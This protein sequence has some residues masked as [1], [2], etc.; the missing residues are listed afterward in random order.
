[1]YITIALTSP[2][3]PREQ[4]IPT[5]A[6]APVES[7]EDV[8]ASLVMGTGKEVEDDSGVE[9]DEEEVVASPVGLFVVFEISA[10]VTVAVEDVVLL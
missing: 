6:L 9:E 1:V 8:V 7:P 3:T 10:P 5:P 2:I 4:A